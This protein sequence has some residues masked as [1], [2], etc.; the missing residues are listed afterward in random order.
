VALQE[1]SEVFMSTFP[2]KAPSAWED[3]VA[4]ALF[5]RRATQPP[6]GGIKGYM[7]RKTVSAAAKAYPELRLGNKPAAV[8]FSKFELKGVVYHDRLSSAKDSQAVFYTADRSDWVPAEI[9]SI[10]VP[11]DAQDELLMAYPILIIREYISLDSCQISADRW[12]R[13]GP[14]AGRVY[15]NDL[16]PARLAF[17]REIIGP[18]ARI[19][20]I[21]V[22]V[23]LDVGPSL[24]IPRDKVGTC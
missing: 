21:G 2:D 19:P 17:P 12:R 7:E 3:T 8:S 16:G 9:S 20:D 14:C 15:R 6:G 11:C 24:F 4:S 13:F 23:G 10:R 18:L 1:F 5:S 22:D